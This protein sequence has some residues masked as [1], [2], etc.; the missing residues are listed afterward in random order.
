M[1]IVVVFD[2][3]VVVVVDVAVVGGG[4]VVAVVVV[5]NVEF[6]VADVAELVGVEVCGVGSMFFSDC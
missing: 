5:G 1:I 3:A 4:F 2:V 6:D